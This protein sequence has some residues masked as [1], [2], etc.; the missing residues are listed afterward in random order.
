MPHVGLKKSVGG[1]PIPASGTVG[2]CVLQFS[3]ADSK[4]IGVFL[5]DELAIG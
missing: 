4:L 1:V 2:E 3:T 5:V